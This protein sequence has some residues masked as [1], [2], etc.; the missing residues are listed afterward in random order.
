[1]TERD[2]GQADGQQGEQ[3]D[4]HI[5]CVGLPTLQLLRSVCGVAVERVYKM[6]WQL[7]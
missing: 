4:C 1:M 3:F 5:V 7:P 6:V 2:Q